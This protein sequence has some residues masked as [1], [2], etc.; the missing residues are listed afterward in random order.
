[1]SSPRRP[2]PAKPSLVDAVVALRRPQ[3]RRFFFAALASNSGTWLQGVAT[4]YVLYTITEEARWVGFG[5]FATMVPMA[6]MGVVAGPLADR[7]PRQRILVVTQCM[8]AVTAMAMGVLWWSGVRTP[9]AYLGVAVA[10]GIV[11]GFNMPAWQAFVSDLVPREE[12]MNAITLNSAQFNAARA[13]GPAVGGLVLAKAGPGWSFTGNAVSYFIVVAV[14]ITL[15]AIMPTDPPEHDSLLNQFRDGMRYARET[16]A[17]RNVYI[18]VALLAVCG[19]TLVSAHIVVFSETVFN[20]SETQ[21][22][23]LV[24]A[25]G[26]GSM[27][28]TPWIAARGPLYRR[29]TLIIGGLVLYGI[30]ELLLTATTLYV[31]GFIGVMITGAAH[32]TSATTNNSTLQL[33]VTEE[34]R[35]R[36]VGLYLMVLTIAMPIGAIFQSLLSDEFGVRW[37]VTGMA[38]LMLLGAAW[39]R[40]SGRIL[41][42]DESAQI[43]TRATL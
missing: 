37:V 3:F 27:L 34:M 13:I 19:G 12:L 1:M 6:I 40:F 9:W 29:S 35:G 17:I 32:I 18:A 33:L 25:F 31:V 15:P 8:M 11:N 16:P 14:L 43:E 10:H 28:V 21:Y 39:L 22:G 5:T 38:V 23:L 24:S 2:S 36:V 41:T 26:I 7:L 20:A 30:G 4:P 42:A